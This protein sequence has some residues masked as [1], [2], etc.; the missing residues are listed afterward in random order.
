MTWESAVSHRQGRPHLERQVAKVA[1]NPLGR[2]YAGINSDVVLR[3][4]EI[5]PGGKLALIDRVSR[6][7]V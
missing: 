7:S 2:G 3:S 4:Y 6:A 5:D 1:G